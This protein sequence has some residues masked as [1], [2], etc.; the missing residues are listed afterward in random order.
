MA[1][2]KGK[3]SKTL[4]WILM[5][6][7]FVGLAGF[8]ATSLTG[9]ARSVATVGEE[10]VSTDAYLLAL[11]N[12][13]NAM[14]AQAG[15]SVPMSEAQSL[16][17][18]RQV[19]SQL[20]T[21][22]ALDNEAG[23]IDLSV[24]DEVVAEQL[25][26]VPSFQGADGRFNRE[27]YRFALRNQG[28]TEA[29]FEERLRDETARS[30]LQSALIA[31]NALPDTYIDTLLAYTGET[32]DFTWAR[33]GPSAMQTGLPEPDEADLRAY[34][35]ENIA[36]Y[37][38][39]ERR[40]ITYVWI[41]PEMILDTVE[42]DEDALRA[43]YEERE[44]EF[45]MPERRLVERLVF[46]DEAAA[47][48]ARERLDGG[49]S[50]EDL[51]TE[52]GLSLGDVDMGDVTSEALGAAGEAVFSAD[53]GAVTDPLPS[54]L[55]PALYRVNAI[56]DAQNTPFE[57][58][59]PVLRDALARDRARR[60]IETLAGEMDDELAAGATLED[61]AETT[62]GELGRI[63]WMPGADGGIAA[64]DA[65]REAAEETAEGDFPEIRQLGDG[66]VF[67]LRLNEIAPPAPQPFE[68]VRDRVRQGWDTRQQTER[69]TARAEEL[70]GELEAGQDFAALG[71]E[72]MR[73]TGLGRNAQIADLPSDLLQ[74]VFDLAPG[75]AI[76]VPGTG[77]A[78][79]V[80]L[81]AIT[82]VDRES[83]TI[84]A[85]EDA[86]REQAAGSVAEDLFRAF[87]V[88]AQRRAGIE[89]NQAAIN[90]V[91]AYIQ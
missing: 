32:R 29:E 44:A 66:G 64:Y 56:L 72:P 24:G 13:L 60:V 70:A 2:G 65:F 86:L 61:L 53:I 3:L 38:L 58:A 40:D 63:D 42:V 54:G 1:M 52:R 67:A 41:T 71:L 91:H 57:E 27:A 51:V 62:E 80:R 88:D 90:S 22:A 43:A 11:R 5:G 31:G 23:R 20:V 6:L 9:S 69:L 34:Y 81:D 50:F 84:T 36:A 39:P 17:L 18:D 77:E 55:G 68:E 15:R 75:A 45:N 73:E 26:Q 16:G 8:G 37:T 10:E 82:P 46:S 79:L 83:E 78:F 7:L 33:L 30:I 89:V 14:S 87:A 85:L 28:L 76:A 35:E 25:L 74:T 19:L 48:A 12:E 59:R 21:A 49:A 4:I 47:A